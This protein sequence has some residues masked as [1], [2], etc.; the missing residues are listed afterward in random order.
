MGDRSGTLSRL[1]VEE[2]VLSLQPDLSISER[3]AIFDKLDVDKSGV[4]DLA[5][6]HRQLNAINAAPFVALE[7]K[8]ALLK[9]TFSANGY[10][11]YES[12][13]AF[14]TDGN[15]FLSRDEWL[16]AMQSMMP[17][18]TAVDADAIFA[19]FDANGDGYLSLVEFND[20]FQ[21]N[22]D[23]KPELQAHV[24]PTYTP[25]P[26]EEPWEKEILDLV[27]DCLSIGRSGMTITEVYRRLD[28][29]HDNKMTSYEFNRMITT[30]RP[31]LTDEHLNSLFYKVNTSRSGAICLSEFVSRFG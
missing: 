31:H 17:T 9:R 3:Q 10:G 20:V 26:L 23:R 2:V 25:P 12:F 27:R 29:D 22:I 7:D 16:A 13:K 19:R 1:E 4:V 15:N 14:D 21:D 5:E 11:Y 18:M 24:W 30:Y 6:F 8:I 28:I